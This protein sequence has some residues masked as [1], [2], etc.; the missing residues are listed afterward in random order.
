VTHVVTSS[1]QN[2]GPFFKPRPLRKI[3]DGSPNLLKG[4]CH[5]GQILNEGPEQEKGQ[6]SR[7]MEESADAVEHKSI[8]P[9]TISHL[10]TICKILL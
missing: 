5:M 8:P 2:T 9:P 7:H 10:I 3:Y 4:D 6:D 1:P